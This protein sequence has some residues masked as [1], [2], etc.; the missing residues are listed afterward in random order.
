MMGSR[1][2]P[3]L[4]EL[5]QRLQLWYESECNGDWEHSFGIK[6]ETL[7]NPGW[8]VTI[9]LAETRWESV[10]VEGVRNNRNETDWV[11]YEVVNKQFIG[12]G[13]T[14]NLAEILSCFFNIVS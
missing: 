5:M 11:Q 14:K 2:N 8:L 7:D 6:I 9:D 10:A 1:T 13:G 3:T 12:C 4:G